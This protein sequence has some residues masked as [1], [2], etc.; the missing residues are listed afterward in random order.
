[1]AIRLVF[2]AFLYLQSPKPGSVSGTVTNAVTGAPVRKAR[3][4]I[5]WGETT[6]NATSDAEGHFAIAS[7]T[8][9]AFTAHV[10]APGFTA[11]Q[12]N[13]AIRVAEDQHVDAGTFSLTPLGVISGRVLDENGDPMARIPVTAQVETFGR[14]GRALS[15][16]GM[17]QTDDR[18]MYR[19]FDLPPGRYLLMAKDPMLSAVP[20]GR[21]RTEAEQTAYV[22][23][24]FPGVTDD[25]QASPSL[26]AAGG[27]L[28]GVDIRLR[29]VRVYHIRGRVVPPGG[30]QRLDSPV[31]LTRCDIPS[32]QSLFAHVLHDGTFD[33]VDV[34]PGL[35]C[36]TIEQI[37]DTSH[38]FYAR[39]VVTVADHDA[40]NVVLTVGAMPDIHGQVLVDGQAPSNLHQNGLRLDP[41][42]S[43][44]RGASMQVHTNGT[45]VNSAILPGT[46]RVSLSLPGMYLKSVRFHDQESADG[47]ITVTEAGGEITLSMATDGGELSGTVQGHAVFAT[48][49]RAGTADVMLA[50]VGP[51]GEF[52]FTGLAPGDY[53]V[54]AWDSRD[55]E[56]IQ[57][58]EF[59][60]QFETRATTATVH[61][62]GHDTVSQV[63][64]VSEAEMEA[65]KTRVR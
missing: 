14:T 47:R 60:K 11:L 63:A 56:L 24:W 25:S 22:T 44:G 43:A 42:G 37:M 64:V 6:Y 20:N 46:Y 3:V 7:V 17:T 2:L 32:G 33:V 21:L 1:M 19:L 5:R 45:F 58:G 53:Q 29:K 4:T 18:G 51:G 28:T 50:G 38:G 62:R 36:L 30:Q 61:S 12:R 39:Q 48:A 35:W 10:D 40:A 54:L 55:F 41:V 26:L 57:Y 9:G 13:E 16:A 65:A 15:T 23:S 52:R 49:A 34:F 8:P 59:R 27:E 31:M